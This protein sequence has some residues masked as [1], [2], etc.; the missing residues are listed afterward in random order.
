[1]QSLTDQVFLRCALACHDLVACKQLTAL[2]MVN[3]KYFTGPEQTLRDDKAPQGTR[4]HSA[5]GVANDV[6]VSNLKSEQGFWVHSCV[7]ACDDG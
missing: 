4:I 7:H 1:M 5:S 2:S 3:D 6:R